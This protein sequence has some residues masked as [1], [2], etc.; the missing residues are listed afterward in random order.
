MH[1]MHL[2]ELRGIE[3]TPARGGIP[4][5]IEPIL[6]EDAIAKAMAPFYSDCPNPLTLE[7]QKEYAEDDEEGTLLSL[8]TEHKGHHWDWY[9]I[10]GRYVDFFQSVREPSA[11]PF[12]GIDAAR[13]SNQVSREIFGRGNERLEPEPVR[14]GFDVILKRDVDWEAMAARRMQHLNEAW[15]KFEA[16]PKDAFWTYGIEKEDTS[17]EAYIERRM[18]DRT[19]GILTASGQWVERETFIYVP[20][21]K[22]RFE[23][24]PDWDRL[25]DQMVASMPDD[26]VLAIVDYHN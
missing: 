24:T 21:G 6:I 12:Q 19:H 9:E 25:W 7:Q 20:E 22:S 15:S 2:V 17:R 11:L 4:A 3:I 16:D 26:A 14:E 18:K 5:Q 10:G 1:Y 23:Q 13:R 8:C